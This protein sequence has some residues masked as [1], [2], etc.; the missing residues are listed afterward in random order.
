MKVKM[1]NKHDIH[2]IS[3]ITED[4]FKLRLQRYGYSSNKI[5]QILNELES[6]KEFETEFK[7]FLKHWCD[8]MFFMKVKKPNYESVKITTDENLALETIKQFSEMNVDCEMRYDS[9]NKIFIIKGWG[10]IKNEKY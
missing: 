3:L 9:Q 8:I 5:R 6:G 10:I 2:D 1:Q 7:I 4:A